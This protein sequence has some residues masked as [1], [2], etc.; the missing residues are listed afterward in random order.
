MGEPGASVLV[1]RGAWWPVTVLTP[2]QMPAREQTARPGMG[3]RGAAA[4]ARW[5]SPSWS[6]RVGSRIAVA[7]L[8]FVEA[9]TTAGIERTASRLLRTRHHPFLQLISSGTWPC[10]N[11]YDERPGTIGTGVLNRDSQPDHP[12]PA[13]V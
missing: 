6:L 3:G 8:H 13:R 9:L 4:A 5:L 12:A 1:S 7:R 11:G 2:S 10:R